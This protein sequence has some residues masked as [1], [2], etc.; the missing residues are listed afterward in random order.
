LGEHSR[1]V[2][3][4]ERL[5][6]EHPLRER[7]AGQLMLALYRSGRQADALEIYRQTSE[8]LRDELGLEP[9]PQL[10]ELERSILNQ[11]ATVQPPPRAATAPPASLPVPATAFVGRRREVAELAA[12]V[13]R[14]ST[15]LLTLTGAGGSGKTRLAL[16][17]A[18]TCAAGYRDG[19]WFVGFADIADPELI[20]PTISQALELAEAAGLEPARR[21]E[22]WLSERQVLLVLDNLEQL[23]DG[24]AVLAEALSACPGLTLLVTSREPLRLAGEQQY[25]VP[26]LEPEDA[27]AL[28]EIRTQAV[29]PGLVVHPKLADAICARLDYLPLA[30]ELAAART[31]ALAPGEILARLDTRLPLLTGGPRDAPRRQQTLR[32]TLDWSYEL[33][34]ANQRRLLAR[35][36]VFAGGCTFGAAE[37]VCGAELDTLHALVDRSLVRTDGERYW[38]LPTL[39]EYAL[40][41]LE[42]TVEAEQLRAVHARWFVELIHSEGLDAHVLF[43]PPLL[44]R[45]RAE[46]E[47]FRSA[48]E[49]AADNGDH[50]ALARLAFPL[51]FY[52][53]ESQGQLQEA[54]RWIEMALGHLAESPPWLRVGVLQ[55]AT[56]LA[57]WRGE[58]TQ[59]Q[60][61]SEQ[62]LA[63]LPEV[64]DSNF[65]C[66]VMM[67]NGILAIQRGDLD[68][69]RSA[70]EDVARLAREHNNL[71]DLSRALIN[72]GDIAIGQGRLEEGRA[73]LEEAIDCSDPGSSP[74]CVAVINLSQIAALQGRY[75][76]AA[77]LGRTALATALDHGDQL[78][79]IW[80]TFH[81]AWA[82]AELGDLERSA[83]LIGAATAFLQTAG[84][85]RDRSDLLCEKGVLDALHGRLPAD[86]VDA[87]VQRGRDMPLE[88]A[89]SEALTES[90][91]LGAALAPPRGSN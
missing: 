10:R 5:V 30:I 51:T 24:S 73:L 78:R 27:V 2:G 69:A 26:V 46:R 68:H 80:A 91:R 36:G 7:P 12:L 17:V 33:L 65:V 49:W 79:A 25:E 76:D 85:A 8:L 54:G 19:T 82:L 87:L 38:M 6:R 67:T 11:D 60:A 13:Q 21:L 72:Q 90:P 15:R 81:V 70:M 52:L 61:L 9:S 57:M 53:W 47:N 88:E 32:A 42:Q 40:E 29:V 74:A 45:V 71:L 37:A 20:V 31:K 63:I 55:A 84:F 1:L 22:Q 64:V 39:R 89:L 35:L 43:T 23:A 56:S 83:R 66:D 44:G 41:R 62:A 48:L 59:A 14:R 18:E 4:L 3:E 86:I 77:S 16:R 50:E 58:L 75:H 28:F 34:D